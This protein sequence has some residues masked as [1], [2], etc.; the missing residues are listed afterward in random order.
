MKRTKSNFSLYIVIALLIVILLAIYTYR[1]FSKN[2]EIEG[3]DIKQNIDYYVITMREENRMK[4]IE[5]QIKKSGIQMNMN[6]IDAVVGKHLDIDEYIAHNKI[7]PNIY[8]NEG[9]KFADKFDNRKN[10]VG[11]YLSHMK[12]YQT[13]KEKGHTDKYS[14]IFE[15]D[16]SLS[17][18]F[19]KV[20][21]ETLDKIAHLDFDML[22]LGMSGETG[23]QVVDNVYFT[24]PY[25]FQ[26]HG[27]LVNNKHIDK[28]ISEMQYIDNIV[29]VQ[30]FKKAH[31]GRLTVLRLQPTIVFQADYGSSIRK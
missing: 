25:S 9:K 5:T 31:E 15:D 4:N 30:I 7:S 12:T 11:C 27:Y 3:F 8:A 29:D 18:D 26:T 19:A 16:F 6:Y 21:E 10:E 22:F 2:I 17:D 20:L 1:L 13:I 24:V 23:K 14:V 28:I